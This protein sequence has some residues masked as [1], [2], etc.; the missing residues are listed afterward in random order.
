MIPL[1]TALACSG[2]PEEALAPPMMGPTRVWAFHSTDGTRWSQQAE[3]V[4]EGLV[5]LG[6]AVADDGELWLSG[7]DHTGVASWWERN[8]TGPPVAGL[9]SRDGRTW[10]ATSWSF[11]DEVDGAAVDPQWFEGSLWYVHHQGTGDPV[12]SGIPNDVRAVPPGAVQLSAVGLADPSPVRFG[13]ELLVFATVYPHAVK[14]YAGEPLAQFTS[15][16]GLTVPFATVV[17][18]ELWL[19][20]QRNVSG[21]RRPVLARSTDGR[22][23]GKASPIDL[24]AAA[25]RSCTSPVLGP[26]PDGFVLLC[27]EETKAS[28]APAGGAP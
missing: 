21:G 19:L 22:S 7:L 20:A 17:G 10:E 15:M 18:D 16:A 8:V 3:P 23:F 27:V 5:S 28:T 14:G 26:T 4:A 12:A 6:L 25:P 13:G 1:L 24:G 9:R 2:T 11:D